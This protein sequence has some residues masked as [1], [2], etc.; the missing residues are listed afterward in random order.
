ME[1]TTFVLVGLAIFLLLRVWGMFFDGKESSTQGIKNS[2]SLERA[3]EFR[4]RMSKLDP[5]HVHGML[6]GV[7]YEL[8]VARRRWPQLELWLKDID[9]EGASEGLK[10]VQKELEVEVISR[11]AAGQLIS[12]G[13]LMPLL[14]A[15]QGIKDVSFTGI[16]IEIWGQFLAERDVAGVAEA[17]E[18]L[19][20]Y[21]EID[22]SVRFKLEDIYFMP[23]A[24]FDAGSAMQGPSV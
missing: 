17:L 13:H 5:V 9:A 6:A 22:P 3:F 20:A 24:L 23:I 21:R 12:A 11:Q 15:V 18:R 19:S 7:I 4:L 2:S 10:E 8:A 16:A 1:Y 14:F